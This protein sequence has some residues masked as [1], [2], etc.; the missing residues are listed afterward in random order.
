MK[1]SNVTHM[2]SVDKDEIFFL[3]EHAVETDTNKTQNFKE[4]N[5][6]IHTCF[7]KVQIHFL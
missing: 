2:Q 3:S 6:K 7:T 5:E 1:S 4:T